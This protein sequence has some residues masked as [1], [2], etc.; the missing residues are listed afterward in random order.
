M[1]ILDRPK[2]EKTRNAMKRSKDDEERKAEK[3][4]SERY[5]VERKCHGNLKFQVR[6]TNTKNAD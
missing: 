6:K 1:F 4:K 5:C 2:Q 3:M